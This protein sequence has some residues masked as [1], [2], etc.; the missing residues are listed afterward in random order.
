MLLLVFTADG[1]RYAL[2]V[3]RVREIVPMVALRGFPDAPPYVR[4]IMNYRG[5][6]APVIDLTVLLAGRQSRRLLSTRIIVTDHDGADGKIH[7]LGL[8]AE[9]VTDTVMTPP[10]AVQGPGIEVSSAPY[11]SG[12]ILDR[13]GL[14][15]VVDPGKILP[16]ALRDALF[17][18]ALESVDAP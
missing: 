9:Q 14:V 15:Q 8:V 16:Q 2:P 13:Q 6:L 11:L 5:E 7:A 3:G 10:E 12:A 1:N 17:T 18:A 4:G